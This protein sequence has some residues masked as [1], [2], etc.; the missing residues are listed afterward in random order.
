MMTSLIG[1]LSLVSALTATSSALSCMECKSETSPCS[2]ILCPPETMCGTVYF[3]G[4]AAGM[5]SQSLHRGCLP[6]SECGNSGTISIKQGRSGVGV[7]CCS[8][9]NCTPGLLKPPQKNHNPNGVICP[10]CATAESTSCDTSDTIQCTGD[11]NICLF[12][13]TKTG[14]LSTAVR[15]CATKSYCDLG[16]QFYNIEGST[17]EVTQS[18]TSGGIS[19]Q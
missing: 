14:E 19:T 1:I 3:Q 7:S 13:T 10:S 5:G 4:L 17:T 12:R 6:L 11:E 18:C 16:R 8:S 9:D 2:S 15:G